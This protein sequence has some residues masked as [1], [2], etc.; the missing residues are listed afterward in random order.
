[1]KVHPEVGFLYIKIGYLY[2]RKGD[3][4]LSALAYKAAL[5]AYGE[6]WSFA[7]GKVHS[8]VVSTWVRL[9]EQLQELKC[10]KEVIVSGRRAL[11]LLR[12]AKDNLYRDAQLSSCSNLETQSKSKTIKVSPIQLTCSTYYDALLTTL[13][14]LGQAHTSLSQYQPAKMACQESLHLAWELALAR[15]LEPAHPLKP[16]SN[17][18]VP[19]IVRIIHALKRLGKVLL[20]QKYY[21]ESL[22]CFLP[23]LQLL[24]SSNELES[25]LDAASV[26][27]SLGFLHLKTERFLEASNFFRECLRLYQK[28]GKLSKQTPGSLSVSLTFL[29]FDNRGRP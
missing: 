3:R 14:C 28:N 2:S 20:L 13:Q 8:E 26:L 11:F 27:G 17:S 18:I 15:S 1:M 23:A 25:T 5:K 6:P 21:S 7:S 9:T 24:R 22:D 29:V 12:Q 16:N 19:S 10:W 4:N